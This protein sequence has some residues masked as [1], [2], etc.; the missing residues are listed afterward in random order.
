M[1]SSRDAAEHVIAISATATGRE[2]A[3][4]GVWRINHDDLTASDIAAWTVT[5][6]VN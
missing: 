4:T 2:V 3:L 6:L 5:A 1:F